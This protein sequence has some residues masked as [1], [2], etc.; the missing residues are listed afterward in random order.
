MSDP[1]P[2]PRLQPF[3]RL[4]ISDG[5]TI[6]AERWQFAHEYH[7]QRQNFQ[8]QA[9]YEPGIVYGLGVAIIPGQPDGRLV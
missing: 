7:R 8:Y 4:Q 6:N 2:Y 3:E 9:L 1:R 5:I